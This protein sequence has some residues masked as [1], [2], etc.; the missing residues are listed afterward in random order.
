MYA[1]ISTDLP[2][3][4]SQ[5]S[6]L[7]PLFGVGNSSLRCL[8][9]LGIGKCFASAAATRN[10]FN[11]PTNGSGAMLELSGDLSAYESAYSFGWNTGMPTVRIGFTLDGAGTKQCTLYNYRVR[12][13]WYEYLYNY[14]GFKIRN[15]YT[16]TVTATTAM[17]PLP[18]EIFRAQQGPVIEYG[19]TPAL[20]L[21]RF[22]LWFVTTD[23]LKHMLLVPAR[24]GS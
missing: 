21:M 6:D 5:T 20:K 18:L 19:S 16:T 22:E 13:N 23:G 8:P 24:K 7:C 3:D 15:L 17:N 10:I 11:T 14:G 1:D 2:C 4:V 9:Y 12:P